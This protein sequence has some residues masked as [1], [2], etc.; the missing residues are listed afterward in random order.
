M[1]DKKLI[2]S[3]RNCPCLYDKTHKDFK[4]REKKRR[5]W[6][7][8]ANNL[9]VDETIAMKRWGNL[10]ERFS[11]E[12]RNPQNTSGSGKQWALLESLQ[13]LRS[14]I[15]SRPMRQSAP[16]LKT[17]IKPD[18]LNESSS[19]SCVLPVQSVQLDSEE[20]TSTFLM[21]SNSISPIKS[22]P[23]TSRIKKRK[24]SL[25]LGEMDTTI[26]ETVKTFQEISTRKAHREEFS[27]EICGFGTMICSAI[28]KMKKSTQAA[29]IRRC[30]DIVMQAQIDEDQRE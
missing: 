21:Q 8:V 14:H 2:E 23:S 9:D 6:I 16:I 20:S 24:S 28:S 18:I 7:E 29:V 1:D 3:V 15:I 13:F 4:D 22:W 10:R 26:G 5:A 19:S 12:I 17:D 27:L 30:T 11:K 25:Q